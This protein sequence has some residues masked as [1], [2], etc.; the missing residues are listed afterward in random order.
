MNW[1]AFLNADSDAVR[2]ISFS[3]TCK[4]QGSTAVAVVVLV[5]IYIYIERKYI[6]RDT[7]TYILIYWRYIFVSCYKILVTMQWKAAIRLL[8]A[9]LW[10][11]HR[12]SS[13]EI[14]FIEIWM[15]ICK[16][17]S[18][19]L[20]VCT[21]RLLFWMSYSIGTSDVIFGKNSQN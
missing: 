6:N 12:D 2:L 19:L 10:P 15:L 1:T 7:D 14:W 21:L 8:V 17:V 20:W 16:M 11:C 4:Y 18:W 3:L 5:Y 13:I 9:F